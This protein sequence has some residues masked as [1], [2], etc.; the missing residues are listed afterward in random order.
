MCA[1]ITSVLWF[2]GYARNNPESLKPTESDAIAHYIKDTGDR[3]K[4]Q[5][6]PITDD[7]IESSE[8]YIF[9]FT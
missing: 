6:E 3:L 4:F 1:H 9:F 2:L 7:E 5:P 8:N